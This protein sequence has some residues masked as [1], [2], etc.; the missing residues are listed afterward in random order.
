MGFLRDALA[1]RGRAFAGPLGLRRPTAATRA[2][3]RNVCHIGSQHRIGTWLARTSQDPGKVSKAPGSCSSS[4]I[5]ADFHPSNSPSTSSF[6]AA[7]PRRRH[8]TARHRAWR[9][10]C[11]VQRRGFAFIRRAPGRKQPHHSMSAAEECFEDSF[12][13]WKWA[14]QS[15]VGRERRAR[16]DQERHRAPRICTLPSCDIV[17]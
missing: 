12:R 4:M 9:R 6:P 2:T 13:L 1:H 15:A 3:S 11:G 5:I 7:S 14:S 10:R 8:P 17:R 16:K